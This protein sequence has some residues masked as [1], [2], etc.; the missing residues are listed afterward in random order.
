MT[1]ASSTLR[2]EGALSDPLRICFP[3]IDLDYGG[4][5]RQLVELALGLDKKEFQVMV[6]PLEAGGPLEVELKDQPGICVH[7]LNRS[8]KY[9]LISPTA[10]LAKLMRSHRIQIVQPFITPATLYGLVAAF[11]NRTPI[12]I[13]TERCGGRQNTGLGN[14]IYRFF[15]D[16]LTRTAD[17]AI[18][19]SEAGRRYLHE[20]GVNPE[21]TRVVY[22]GVNQQRLVA[23][24]AKS[25]AIRKSLNVPND[26]VLLGNVSR[27]VA[28]KRIDLLIKATEVLLKE[29]PNI[30]LA[31]VGDGPDHSDL[32]ALTK[33][34]GIA[35]HVEFLG[36]HLEVAPF[37]DCFDVAVL[38]S[39]DLEGCS[40]FLLEAMGM[41]KP[42]V[43]SDF[44]GN[45][46]LVVEGENG[47]IVPSGNLE[48]LVK[49]LRGVIVN[50]ELR[51]SMGEQGRKMVQTRFSLAGMV[52]SYR[53]TYLKLAQSKIGHSISGTEAAL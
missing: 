17:L 33:S 51:R 34:L 5:Q 39:V 53:N 45:S 31:L 30:R 52:E 11:M 49:A 18:A 23:N 32:K 15:E 46:E 43:A 6:V 9:D 22:N 44:G 25:L 40:N 48:A 7:A 16:Q 42:V 19:N 10:S 50:K 8:R 37:I 3:I 13:V 29:F 36:S 38:S 41:G 47:Y 26:G 24:P 12:R 2:R 4:A 27:H 35:A 14:R 1:A 20:R 28:A 21:I